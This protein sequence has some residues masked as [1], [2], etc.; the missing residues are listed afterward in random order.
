M[1]ER[2]TI[3][4]LTY[5][6]QRADFRGLRF[7][8]ITPTDVDG[9]I[10]FEGRCCIFMETKH[11]DADLPT[12][13]RLWLER[14]CDKWGDNGIV[15]VVRNAEVANGSPTYRIGELPVV[16]Y[17]H[18]CKW[19]TPKKR[20]IC[21]RWIERFASARLGRDVRAEG[22]SELAATSIITSTPLGFEAVTE[23]EVPF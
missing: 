23:I 8:T 18:A 7:G 12:G 20:A 1:S 2:G 11:G 5:T 15:L 16:E 4:N 6:R 13:Q 19:K 14:N 22:S 9:S 10:E 21:V 3:R 17:R